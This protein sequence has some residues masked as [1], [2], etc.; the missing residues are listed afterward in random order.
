[1]ATLVKHSGAGRSRRRDPFALLEPPGWHGGPGNESPA[2]F[3]TA[4]KEPMRPKSVLRLSGS[5]MS[6]WQSPDLRPTETTSLS[7]LFQCLLHGGSD[8]Y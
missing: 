7:F 3:A 4:S 8:G 5:E 1:M 6:A 2:A